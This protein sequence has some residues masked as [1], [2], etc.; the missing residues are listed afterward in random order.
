[1]LKRAWL[2]VSILWAAFILVAVNWSMAGARMTGRESLDTSLI[3]FL[4]FAIGIALK[5]LARF[6]VLGH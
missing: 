2:V 3:A 1:M 4:P 5:Y 6:I